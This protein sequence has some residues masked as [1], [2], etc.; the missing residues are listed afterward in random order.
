MIRDFLGKCDVRDAGRREKLFSASYPGMDI[1]IT[2]GHDILRYNGTHLRKGFTLDSRYVLFSIGPID[3]SGRF[4]LLS[5]VSALTKMYEQNRFVEGQKRIALNCT[6]EDG[7]SAFVYCEK[8]FIK[9][10]YPGMLL[11]VE[12]NNEDCGA[13]LS[14]IKVFEMQD[15]LNKAKNWLAPEAR[16]LELQYM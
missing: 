10:Q 2:I 7:S 14:Q 15:A 5:A 12:Y 13:V 8:K 3:D 6:L 11:G 16:V 1:N 9:G 4:P